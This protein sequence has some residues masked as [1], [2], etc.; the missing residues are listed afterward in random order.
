MYMEAII[1]AL[2]LRQF[3]TKSNRSSK[4]LSIQN[5]YTSTIDETHNHV[6]IGM[7]LM[8]R[9]QLSPDDIL[10]LTNTAECDNTGVCAT[11]DESI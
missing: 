3:L 9:I 1:I 10:K 7:I 8:S 5:T 11:L 2:L 6:G 4:F